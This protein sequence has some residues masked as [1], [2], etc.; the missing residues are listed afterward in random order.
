MASPASHRTL[1]PAG[2]RL[3]YIPGWGDRSGW[4]S[5]Q[6]AV[7]M[8][9]M[10][11][12]GSCIGSSMLDQLS[13]PTLPAMSRPGGRWLFWLT[14]ALLTLLI[15]LACWQW[16]GS[17]TLALGTPTDAIYLSGFNAPEQ[18]SLG[19]YRWSQPDAQVQLPAIRAP[20]LLTLRMAA[21]PGS[22]PISLAI[23]N[24][25]L[26]QI[27]LTPTIAR[28]YQLLWQGATA[29][30]GD[31][32][33]GIHSNDQPATHDPRALGVLISSITIHTLPGSALPPLL[34]LALLG[35]LA[36]LAAG[37]L[38]LAGLPLRLA[39]LC[40]TLAGCALALAW[41]LARLWVGP[42]LGISALAL[43][44]ITLVLAG[45]RLGAYRS[46][47]LREPELLACFA[48]ASSLIPCYLYA[49][50]GWRDWRDLQNILLL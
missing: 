49:D 17:L 32:I 29:P 4:P 3:T 16:S 45:L 13:S 26:L 22:G 42:Y 20:A 30:D 1:S 46:P 6:M 19:H 39:L 12:T 41:G 50:Y 23:D 11:S 24:H 25:R 36:T 48:V 14:P 40:A 2:C 7:C 47:T 28:R 9:R 33:L 8:S 37:L 43:A 34:P 18:G 38:R 5:R 44:S 10:T 27:T 35:T 15:S 31:M 21:R